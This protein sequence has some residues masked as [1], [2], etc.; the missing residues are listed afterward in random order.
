VPFRELRIARLGLAIQS[1]LTEITG[2]SYVP[3]VDPRFCHTVGLLNRR[4]DLTLDCSSVTNVALITQDEYAEKLERL[5]QNRESWI[6]AALIIREIRDRKLYLF[7]YRTFDEFC[8]GELATGRSNADRISASAG[9]AEMLPADIA[10][11]ETEAQVRPLLSLTDA[12][13]RLQAYRIAVARSNKQGRPL[14]GSDVSRAVR[15]IR[16]GKPREV[17]KTLKPVPTTGVETNYCG[18]PGDALEVRA[19]Q[20]PSHM[21][22]ENLREADSYIVG[23]RQ[24]ADTVETHPLTSDSTA[25]QQKTF[26][27]E[28]KNEEDIRAWAICW[29]RGRGYTI[30][31][32]GEECEIIQPNALRKRCG[33]KSAAFSFR[34]NHPDCPPFR[35]IR[36]KSGRIKWLVTNPDLIA[37]MRRPLRHEMI[38][39][40]SL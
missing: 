26:T 11:P 23:V 29:L 13:Q 37:W 7:Q 27:L 32:P 21:A 36:G 31:R 8:C 19:A 9:I 40:A 1:S 5:K 39:S 18:P 30:E 16:A 24:A 3:E 20:A 35:S 17:K 4:T 28:F 22:S 34:L 6:G 2:S 25:D 33:L 12:S 14:A 15:E 10:K 38:R